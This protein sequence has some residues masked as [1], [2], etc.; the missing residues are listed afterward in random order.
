MADQTWKVQ[1]RF[2]SQD[3]LSKA[4]ER[5]DEHVAAHGL[6]EVS[7]I[8]HGG[9]PLL[10]GPDRL[11]KYC[12][13]IRESVRCNV[14]FGLQTNGTLINERFVEVFRR[15]GIKAGISVD[16][17]PA[18]HDNYRVFRNG[19]G[20]SRFVQRG[21]DLLVR[22]KQLGGILCVINLTND[23]VQTYRYLAN[24]GAPQVD[25]LLPHGNWVQLP[26]RVS[27][28]HETKEYAEW[29]LR[30]F[31]VWYE[32]DQAPGIRTFESIMRLLLG[33]DS[34]VESIGP[35]SGDLVVVESNG[36]IEAVDSL[37]SCY[38]G[39]AQTGLSIQMNC[40]DEALSLPP[41][42]SRQLGLNGLCNIC[43]S[44]KY[45]QVCGGGY[46]PHRYSN[47]NGFLNPSIYC[48]AL[49]LLIKTIAE[50]MS[51]DLDLA[52]VHLDLPKLGSARS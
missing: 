8:F 24:S 40:F 20:S 19:E 32:D 18:N 1:S 2:M 12:K 11:D 34:L 17:L 35:D 29:L 23:P 28:A 45:A 49:M 5:V 7:I 30:I 10:L 27:N 3:I 37:K 50:R 43:R 46:Q 9:E 15:H 41:F 13:V 36:N 22:N 51:Q 38:P 6:N 33:E 44:C 31:D 16:G 26:P 52:G 48:S 47:T 14:R 25:F 39:G 4:A 42:F 21:L